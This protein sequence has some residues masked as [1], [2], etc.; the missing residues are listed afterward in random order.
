MRKMKANWNLTIEC[1][2]SGRNGTAT[3]T[4]KIG[5]RSVGRRIVQPDEGQGPSRFRR[6]GLQVTGPASTGRRSN[7]ELLRLAADLAAKPEAPAEPAELP[8]LDAA[9]IVRPE[10]FI[11]PEVSGLAVP[12][13]T[14]MGDNG[15]SADGCSICDG[16]DGKRERRPMAPALELP[17]GRRLWIHPEPSEPTPNM[18]PGW[19]A[20]ARK[21][22]MEGEPAPNPAD[23]FKAM[24]SMFADFIDL[25]AAHAPGVTATAVCWAM[26]TY[27]YSAW[28][29]VPYLYIGGPLGSGK[30]RLFEVLG[31]A[32]LSAVVVIEHDRRGAVPHPPLPKAVSCSWTKPS[33]CGTRKTRRRRKSFRCCWR[34]TRSGGTAT[35]LEPVGDSGFK[36]V[37]FDVFGPKALA[38]I[39]GLPPALASRA[40]PVTMFRSPPGSEKPRRRIDA[41]PDGWQRS[42]R[43][44]ARAGAWNTA[45]P[46]WNCPANRRMPGDARLR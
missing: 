37:S 20:A 13:M 18:K 44:P 32:G 12:S 38:C 21:R 30:S 10:R 8:E 34:A 15:S 3:L 36:T 27:C 33:D 46:G 45:R 29:A 43:R 24:A 22:W 28:D 31:S 42:A 19:S 1:V 11:T 40:I 2:P 41:D 35:R 16:P 5:R 7:A 9:A 23:V 26:L 39:A 17:D 14:T 6:R 25:P 4:A